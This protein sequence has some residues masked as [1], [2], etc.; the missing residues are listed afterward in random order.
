M[1]IRLLQ[2]QLTAG[3]VRGYFLDLQAED[4]ATDLAMVHSRFSTNTFPSWN[5]AQPLRAICHNGEINTLR[6]NLNWMR[7]RQ[8]NISGE[9]FGLSDDELKELFPLV[10]DKILSDSGAFNA[11]LELLVAGGRSAPEAVMMMIPEAWQN[12]A[13]MSEER[14]AFYEYMSALMEPWDGPALIAFTD[15]RYLGATLDRNGLR[16]GRYYET[17]DGRVIMGSEFG[18]VD[19][20]PD[21]IKTKGRLCPGKMLV[22]DFEEKRIVEDDEL[23][24]RY[25]LTKS[26]CC[27]CTVQ[28]C[29]EEPL[30]GVARYATA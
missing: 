20:R 3:Q 14:K 5:R 1:L 19:M 24:A 18:V 26:Y 7:S 13:T 4:F 29:V 8:G 15:G 23:K 11:V 30:S 6:G 25:L 21:L 10:A 12:H 22:V 28:V 27:S 16:P 2:G 17:T 9:H